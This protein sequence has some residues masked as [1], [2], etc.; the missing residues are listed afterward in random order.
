M[1]HHI[2]LPRPRSLIRAGRQIADLVS[3][4]VHETVVRD[5]VPVES[6]VGIWR[7]QSTAESVDDASVTS[8]DGTR[9]SEVVGDFRERVM[10][11]RPGQH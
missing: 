8:L 2:L 1:Q 7:L 5:V 10:A 9:D 11:R 4:L 6:I 3:D